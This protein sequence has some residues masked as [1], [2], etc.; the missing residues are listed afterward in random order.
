VQAAAQALPG[1]AL[2]PAGLTIVQAFIDL[3]GDGEQDEGEAGVGGVSV[4]F[5]GAG[6]GNATTSPNGR[7]L[8][9]GLT[10]GSYTVSAAA[11]AGYAAVPTQQVILENGGA[12]QLP[13]QLP[14]MVSG[15]LYA[16]WDGDNRQQPDELALRLPFTVTLSSG[17]GI[18]QAESAAGVA[19]FLANPAGDYTLGATVAAVQPQAFSLAAGEAKSVG[20]AVAAPNTVRGT[21]WLDG[22][23]DSIRQPWEA[24]LA[25]IT[26]SLSNAQST[27]T[28]QYG[29]YV[30]ED[31]S[32]GAYT[33]AVAAPVGL[34][35]RSPSV[36]VTDQRGAVAALPGTGVYRILLPMVNR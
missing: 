20:L 1:I 11:P 18:R 30:F 9:A 8:L 28:D 15:V 16:D 5:S 27:I 3:D 35:F 2:R 24:P 10:D 4:T 26:V 19:S 21:A 33:L 22:N 14:G 7:A 36:S 31:V 23:G 34:E 12:I 13:L 17:A 32:P 25:G 6:A 29:R